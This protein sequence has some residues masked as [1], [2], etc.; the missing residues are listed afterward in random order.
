[1]DGIERA[2]QSVN[3]QLGSLRRSRKLI[4]RMGSKFIPFNHFTPSLVE[5]IGRKGVLEATIETPYGVIQVF[6][7]HLHMGMNF[8]ARSARV[9]QLKSVIERIKSHRY[10]PIIL[11]GDFN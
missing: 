9:K 1:M 10:L 8:F 4:E 11:A 5:R 3:L 2:V 6:N 7:I